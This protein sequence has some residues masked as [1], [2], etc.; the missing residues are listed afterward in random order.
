MKKRRPKSF[1][2][3]I[4]SLLCIL[5]ALFLLNG[6]AA[7]LKTTIELKK[8]AKL[9][10]EVLQQLKAENAELIAQK[11]KLEDVNYVQSYAR[12]N[13]MLSKDGEQIFYFP[14]E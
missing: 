2:F 10:E 1:V 6:V 3:K 4:I 12:G 7:E 9:A 13:Y 8:K 5:L 11:A 14:N